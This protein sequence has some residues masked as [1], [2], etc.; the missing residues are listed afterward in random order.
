MS[1]S[2][3]ESSPKKADPKKNAS[4]TIGGK[5]DALVACLVEINNRNRQED[6]AHTERQYR[7]EKKLF[8]LEFAGI[9]GLAVYC[10]FTAMEWNTFDSE[11]EMMGKEFAASQTNFATQLNEMREQRVL[12]ERAWLGF[13]STFALNHPYDGEHNIGIQATVVN[14]GKTPAM[15]ENVHL[16][17]GIINDPFIGT[18]WTTNWFLERDYTGFIVP[19]N[20]QNSLM[21]FE[22]KPIGSDNFV[23]LSNKKQ[24]HIFVIKIRY[25]DVFG[26]LRYTES[27]GFAITGTV[28]SAL[29]EL[30]PAIGSG[31]MR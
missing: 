31:I 11:R 16:S 28:E 27:P 12:D 29:G 13:T 26:N 3:P 8:W 19:P 24:V 25:R 20:G 15:V 22:A 14:T 30:R 1:D 23:L 9:I 18:N 4:D 7:L 5:I 6:S 21:F 2:P 17:V 10:V